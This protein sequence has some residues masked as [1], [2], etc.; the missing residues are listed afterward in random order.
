MIE[1]LLPAGPVVSQPGAGPYRIAAA[2]GAVTALASRVTAALR[3]SALPVR[4]A[5]VSSET[6]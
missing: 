6:D 2:Y 1:I 5:P 3:A 4:A